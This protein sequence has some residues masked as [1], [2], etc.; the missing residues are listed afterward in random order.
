MPLS[1]ANNRLYTRS[2]QLVGQNA[3]GLSISNLSEISESLADAD[4]LIIDNG[5]D[6]GTN[7][8]FAASRIPT[9]VFTKVS[10]AITINSS[11]VASLGTNAEGTNLTLSGNLTVN[12]TTTNVSSTTVT[13]D[14]PLFALADNNSADSVDI[15]W[16]GK[17][18]DSGTKYSG[19]F[20]D[21]SDSDMWKLFAT[22][23]NSNAAPSTTVDTTSGFALAN[24]SVNEL[25][26]TIATAA[27]GNITSLGTLSALTV[28]DVA[29]DGKV[30]TMTGSSGDTATI[31]VG[32]N[33]TL[34]I[35][36]TDTAAAAANI[37][38]TADGTAELAGTTVTLDSEG[39]ITLDA[40]GGTITFSDDG[41]SLGTITSSGYSGTAAVAT[42]VTIT[43]NESTNEDNAVVFTAGGDVDGGNLGLESDGNLTYNPSSGTLTST[44]FSGNL[45]GNVTGTA[46]IATTVT[47]T[48]NES[49]DEDNAVVFTAGGDVDGG[50]LGLESDG[51]LTYNPST[52]TLSATS[53][54]GTITTASQTNI[55]AVGTIGTG[56]WQG[57][58]IADTYLA[59]IST[60]DKVA[61]GAIQIDSGTDG[62]SITVAGTDKLLL[63][64]G[65]TTKY[66]NVSQISDFVSAG[67]ITGVTAGNGLSGGGTT[68]GVTLA[69]DLDELS[70]ATVAQA[71][72]SIVII[73]A[74][75]SNS[76]KKE[77]IAD[78]V[79]AIAGTGLSASSGQLNASAGAITALNNATE[80]ELVTVGSTTT[81]LDA[82]T[83][84]TF[85]GTDLKLYK[86]ANNADVS[87]SLGTSATEALTIQV[88]N[89][90]SNKTAEE[91]HFSTATAS[92][93]G[94]HGKLV[95]DVD[96]SDIL[97]I[98]DGGISIAASSAYEVAGTAILSDSSGTM[99]LSNIDALD[100]T[101]EATIE[102]AID[103]LSNLTSIG[104][105][106][107]TTNIV[108][109]DV[110]MYNAV[111]DGNPTISL[112]AAS[113]ERLV[114]TST[115]DSGAQ[116]LDK[117]TFST[118]AASSSSDKGKMVFNVDGTDIFDID[119]S[120]INL[121]SGKT[122]R[123]NG[124]AIDGDITSVVAGTGL[125]GGGTDGDVTLNVAAGNLIDVQADQVDVDLTEAG[126]AAIADGD[127]ILFL[128][129]GA[130]GSH[131]KENIADVATLFAG[132][133]L[134]ASSSVIAVDSSQAITALTGGDLT[135]YED[136]NNADV[137]FKM[138]T[139]A[140]EALSIEVLNGS[141]N[142]T[143]ES[144]T[145]STA[146][147]SSTSDHGKFT[148]NV[149]GTDIF[150]ID[151]SG[152]NLASG[153][154]FRIN[155]TT[156]DGDITGVTAGN[157][158]SGG[159]TD[160]AITL[161][162]DLS[163]LTDTAIA[164]G[165][166]IVFTDTTDSNATVKGDLADVATLFAG[167]GLTASSSVIGVDASQAITALTGGD[168]TI[169][170]DANNADVSLKM[171]T[172]AAESLTIQVLNGASNKTAEEVHFSTATASSTANHG[173]MVF[174]IDGT[175]IL[176]IDDGGIDIAS[177]KT[178]A[179]N[180]TDIVSAAGA[181]TGI[182]SLL[183]TDIKIGEDD[184]TKIDF[185]DADT[186]NFYANNSKEVVLS[187]NSLTPGTS[188]GTALGTA[189]LMWSDLFLASGGVVNF[190]N[191]DITLT[192]S[193]NDLAVGGGTLTADGGVK[194]DDITIDGTEIDL[195]SG[196]LT[197]DVAGDIILDADGD[198]ITFK[199]G[200]GDSN[201]LS[202]TNSSGSWTL[203]TNTSDADL[204]IAGND[205]GSNVDALSFDMSDA[206]K[207][208]FNGAVVVGGDLTVN[209]TTTTVN[210][211]TTT[212]DDPIMTLGGDSA[213]GSDDNKDRGI[214]FR[215]HDGSSAKLGFFGFDD[216]T[217]RL[218]FIPDASNS[219]EV[220]S[221]TK[222]DIDVT[223]VY[224]TVAT[225]SQG[226]ITTLAGLTTIG[227]VSNALAMTYS[228]VTLFH[229]AN[230]AD[231]SFSIGTS[232]A[233]ALKI[234]VL[235]GGSNKTAEE[236]HFSTATASSTA[237]HGKM[238]FDIDG[239]DQMEI[240][241]S[242]VS[243]TGD[244]TITGDD[245][246]MNTNTAGHILVGDDTNYN[247]VAISGDVTLSSS[248]AVTIAN[249]A[250]ESGMLND[251]VISGQTEISSGLADAD[252]LLYS[253][254]G[255]LKKVGLD[256]LTTHV[257]S[258]NATKGFATAMA[259]AL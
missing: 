11:G 252:E 147:A 175:D 211:T 89:G 54:A 53:L 41:V 110:T 120:G 205:G 66:I 170:E 29:I 63:D 100:A 232:A 10:G 97:T 238:V 148:F 201:G 239:T 77:S 42:T 16:Y 34:D 155:G 111:N 3:A 80:N 259:I 25:T 24:L 137:S 212:V 254:G 189:S 255:T 101:T 171:G 76:S 151:D 250:V 79:S 115:Y 59:T 143:A 178:V 70:A 84:L 186:I 237:N 37:Q 185:E 18:V 180:G 194:V 223:N 235:N 210:S 214:E 55:T 26:G 258:S 112:G 22:T 245:L 125:T 56:T 88:L 249:D 102:A 119:D 227:T 188:D 184:E 113:A 159:G 135:L 146:T 32:T 192:H 225:A 133:G 12:G 132:T 209:G 21:A 98:D 204:V 13:I 195:S 1:Q 129:G 145:F 49:T 64:D 197:V 73:D 122:F 69:L 83:A 131:A 103:T 140:T 161:A 213:P 176:T 179:I 17:Y 251:N 95:F 217:G 60:A 218:S 134:T 46:S 78:F 126:E 163:E 130:T 162:L 6:G 196:D 47:I 183:A 193:S 141:G 242:G 118:A 90:G 31:T 187:E 39:G 253:D 164:N 207:A 246:F 206:G 221:G 92:S 198:D 96:G 228:D 231:T 167:T 150:D 142:K 50:N 30:V 86:D 160:G 174:D 156:I 222:G 177:G 74:D 215:W 5:G 124:T 202:F 62:T 203:K 65:G 216:S 108:A 15:G 94:D 48:D 107:A 256:T 219:S 67:D 23:G 51:N 43:D 241:D 35:T 168:L 181:I 226:S 33:G 8:N 172:G 123:I 200:S 191:G 149:D 71:S 166:Y 2:S 229:D 136:A 105:A 28:D 44:T 27:Q 19:L 85:D 40:N 9:Y 182:T 127:Y 138:G 247:P 157:G 152:I 99:T 117:V 61:G 38:I 248:G 58:A 14:D 154:S 257:N 236:I 109:G 4:L 144:V 230:N 128:D 82:E 52:G 81:E 190:N 57:T 244:L 91:V 234:E 20:R 114:I 240:N 93:T 121:A 243:I 106:G 72:D 165:D 224:G 116:T 153:K 75:D 208:T 169:Y 45:T 36:T 68:G 220:F 233:E 173:K 199:A 7:V 87:F 104:A 139:S 158:L